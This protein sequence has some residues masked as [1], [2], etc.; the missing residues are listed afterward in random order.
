VNH[1][2]AAYFKPS[3]R[4][5]GVFIPEAIPDRAQIPSPP[6]LQ[7]LLKDYKGNQALASI[8]TF[9]ASPAN[10]DAKTKTLTLAGG[11]KY[12]LLKKATRGE[13]VNISITLRI[14]SETTLQN[15]ATAA[16][17]TANILMR[18]TKN[19][20]YQQINDAFDKMKA[21]VTI[22]GSGQSVI[23]TIQ[24]LKENLSAT[25]KLV[26]EI[27]HQPSFPADEFEK[28]KQEQL[29]AVEQQKSDPQAIASNI[30]QRN[31]KPYP[32]GHFRYTMTFDEKVAAIKALTL[33]DV[34]KF[35][36]D[37]YQSSNATAA[38][39]GDFDETAVT[40]ELSSML[41]NWSSPVK[42]EH[43]K[44]AYFD[45]ASKTEKINTPDK[46]N[47]VLF[48]GCNLELKDDDADYAALVM[49]DYM[50]GGGFLNSRL[51]VRIRQ[52]EGI[53]Y[54]VG[55][56]ISAD[57]ID[58]SGSFGSYA[59]YNPDNN[60][61]LVVAYKEELDKM[62]KDGFKPDELKDAVSGYLQE[63][64]V[65]RSQDRSLANKLANNLFLNRTMKFDE[66]KESKIVMLKPEDVNAAMKKW[67]NPE[68]ISYVEAGD[69]ERKK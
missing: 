17:F 10:I 15:K 13:S 43:A 31:T 19:K 36:S 46:Q 33:D 62:L 38:V 65:N 54:G 63:Q 24:T 37:F 8:E 48:A 47:A 67:I 58:K 18:G 4:T 6:D 12:A 56:W 39:V 29:G 59:I 23:I 26:N 64:Q 5:G 42:Y 40:S 1:T 9:D 7:A 20:T 61:K 22:Y 69:L 60:D 52:K 55:S 50:L 16:D 14:G 32:K 35:Y 66:G 68:K 49:G 34:K 27:L 3:N 45:I 53:S 51:A 21:D 41:Q 2:V 30:F 28:L 25:L 44:A 57:A 11:A